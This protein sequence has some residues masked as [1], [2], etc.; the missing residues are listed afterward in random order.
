[1]IYTVETGEAWEFATTIGCHKDEVKALEQG[2][3]ESERLEAEKI[4]G[5]YVYV[6]QWRTNGKPATIAD[7]IWTDNDNLKIT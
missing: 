4:N 2:A 6:N 5:Q 3:V 7:C 1:M